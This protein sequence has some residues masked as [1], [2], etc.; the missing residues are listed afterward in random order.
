MSPRKFSAVGAAVSAVGVILLSLAFTIT[1]ATAQTGPVCP[2]G[3]VQDYDPCLPDVAA[4]ACADLD[5]AVGNRGFVFIVGGDPYGLDDNDGGG[6]PTGPGSDG[7]TLGCDGP[8]DDA[9]NPL[10][11]RALA[12]AA[13]G[14]PL[15]GRVQPDPVDTTTTTTVA[16]DTSTT[17]S[18]VPDDTTTTTTSSTTTTVVA[19]G[20]AETTTTTAPDT[21]DTTTTTSS[22][23]TTST[24]VD[25]DGAAGS[26]ELIV[27]N[28]DWVAL[29]GDLDCRHFSGPVDVSDGD[30]FGLD[31]DGD[32]VGCEET[33]VLSGTLPRT[34][35]DATGAA[36][37]GVALLGAGGLFVAAG[38]LLGR[39]QVAQ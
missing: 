20:T 9:G 12:V 19:D 3:F 21:D 30:P 6:G 10:Q 31:V 16:D 13:F 4:L 1:P 34:G 36:Q 25:P 35:G 38:Q 5:D 32:G 8:H 18:T 22:T 39:R 27:F 7:L 26:V 29:Y 14:T 2:D 17:T 33:R 15:P 24:T 11:A 23:S 37:A 28:F